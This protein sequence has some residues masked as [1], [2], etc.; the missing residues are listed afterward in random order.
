MTL[1]NFCSPTILYIVFSLTHIV[2]DMFKGMYNQAL[3]KFIMMIGF[4]FVLNFLCQRGLGIISWLI[5]FIP[6]ITM[7][8]I[9]TLILFGLGISPSKEKFNYNVEY[10]NG[11]K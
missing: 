8:I 11:S 4:S 10:P 9:T 1:E 5:V 6:F 3:L 7:T 2:I